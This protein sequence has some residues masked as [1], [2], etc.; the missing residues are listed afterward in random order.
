MKM[1]TRNQALVFEDALIDLLTQHLSDGLDADAIKL[2]LEY[3]ARNVH[4]LSANLAETASQT[5]N[6]WSGG[7]AA[8]H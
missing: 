3:Q 5:G 2:A 4:E 6:A 7:F 1:A 8:N